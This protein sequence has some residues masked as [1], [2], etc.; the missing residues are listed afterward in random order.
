MELKRKAMAYIT[1]GKRLLVFS[2]PDFPA[3]GVQVPKGTLKAGESPAEGVMREAFEE[4]G[5]KDLRLDSFLGVYD[6]PFPELGELQR[7]Y[8]YHLVCDNSPQERWQHWETDPGNG[9]PDPIRFEFFWAD[10]PDGL[11][12]LQ[13][14]H[15]RMLPAL[16]EKIAEKVASE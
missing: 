9:T 14:G 15:D 4:T 2:H 8:F 1:T 3:A 12:Q 5:L 11:P 6:H 13:P 16:M 10:L 7:R